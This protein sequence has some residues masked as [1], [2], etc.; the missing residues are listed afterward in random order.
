MFTAHCVLSPDY[1]NAWLTKPLSFDTKPTSIVEIFTYW[2]HTSFGKRNTIILPKVSQSSSSNVLLSFKLL[3]HRPFF[4]QVFMERHL[5]PEHMKRER[6]LHAKRFL[7][8]GFPGSGPD[9]AHDDLPPAK[10]QRLG[11]VGDT[12]DAPQKIFS[13]IEVQQLHTL[14][15]ERYRRPKR[16]WRKF[17]K[18]KKK[19]KSALTFWNSPSTESL[20]S[21]CPSIA[22]SSAE[23]LSEKMVPKKNHAAIQQW[24]DMVAAGQDHGST[25]SS[26]Q[27]GKWVDGLVCDPSTGCETGDV[28]RISDHT[29]SSCCPTSPALSACSQSSEELAI[30]NAQEPEDFS[31]LRLHQWF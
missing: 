19:R 6:Q 12:I 7:N 18:P 17:C 8:D 16:P 9:I 3:T 23:P 11:S 4:I 20:S 30:W 21:N 31:N 25:G 2:I 29:C 14:V 28:G 15:V 1:T 24:R 13:H 22:P 26:V 27:S 5:R 10:R